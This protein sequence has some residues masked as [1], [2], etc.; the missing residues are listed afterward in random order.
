MTVKP[1]LFL[2]HVILEKKDGYDI[3]HANRDSLD[4]RRCNLRYAK[5]CENVQ[6]RGLL[7]SNSSGYI[8]VSFSKS[9]NM[10][11]SRIQ[12]MRKT[13][14][15]GYFNDPKEAAKIRDI[16]ALKIHKEFAVL[17]F[18]ERLRDD[19]TYDES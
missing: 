4:N 10:Y 16:Y 12:S 15:L 5:C 8:G 1:H 14:D 7:K 13:F 18:P 19:G 3:D 17:N 2:H 11:W 6:N 9:R